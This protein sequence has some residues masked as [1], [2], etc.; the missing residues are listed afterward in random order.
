M[1]Q[2]CTV[3]FDTF[4]KI[5]IFRL[6]LLVWG[7]LLKIN[8]NIF[9]DVVT[10]CHLVSKEAKLVLRVLDDFILFFFT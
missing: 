9:L 3:Y 6:S 4:M 5:T 2:L 7:F 1:C 8:K 10:Q